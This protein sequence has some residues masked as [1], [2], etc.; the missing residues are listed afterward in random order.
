MNYL[1]K[2]GLG[3]NF[4]KKAERTG[5]NLFKKAGEFVNNLPSVANQVGNTVKNVANEIQK[6]TAQ[7]APIA[8]SIAYSLGQPQL[9]ALIGSTALKLNNFANNAHNVVNNAHNASNLLAQ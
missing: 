8:S 2:V 1:K 3:S 6:K 9:G 7:Y 4:F 5:A